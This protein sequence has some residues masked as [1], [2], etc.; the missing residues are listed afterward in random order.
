MFVGI[1]KPALLAPMRFDDGQSFYT[2]TYEGG[3]ELVVI[4]RGD[5]KNPV[6][7]ATLTSNNSAPLCFVTRDMCGPGRKYQSKH[8]VWQR[9]DGNSGRFIDMDLA[10]LSCQPLPA[11]HIYCRPATADGVLSYWKVTPVKRPLPDKQSESSPSDKSE[12][13]E[14]DEDKGDKGCDEEYDENENENEEVE[15]DGDVRNNGGR[16]GDGDGGA[17]ESAI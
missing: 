9:K 12:R 2:P 10:V 15:D 13:K 14:E 3:G 16:G 5:T 6:V 17:S 11:H 7:L 4:T 8:W 1:G